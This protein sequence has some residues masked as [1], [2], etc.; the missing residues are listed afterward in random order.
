MILWLFRNK[1]HIA[2]VG[3][4]LGCMIWDLAKT[5]LIG[6]VG[7]AAIGLADLADL[8]DLVTFIGRSFTIC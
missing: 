1:L 4:W 2:I 6:W 7:L 5:G 3:S 8:A